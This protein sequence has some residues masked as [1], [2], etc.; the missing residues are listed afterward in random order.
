MAQ[1]FLRTSLYRIRFVDLLSTDRAKFRQQGKRLSGLFSPN[2][3]K[4]LS[5]NFCVVSQTGSSVHFTVCDYCCDY[6]A[7]ELKLCREKSTQTPKSVC[8]NRAYAVGEL[9]KLTGGDF[10]HENVIKANYSLNV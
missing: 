4:V 2:F 9:P 7:N 1:D 10:S 3:A 6:A 8:Q 5:S